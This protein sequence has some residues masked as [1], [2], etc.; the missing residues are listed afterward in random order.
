MQKKRRIY[1]QGLIVALLA[2]VPGAALPEEPL[3]PVPPPAYGN[4]AAQSPSHLRKLELDSLLA[5]LDRAQRQLDVARKA[6]RE[7]GQGTESDALLDSTQQVLD[8]ARARLLGEPTPQND[9]LSRENLLRTLRDSQD[10]LDRA[11]ERLAGRPGSE[12]GIAGLDEAQ[13]RLDA[14]KARLQGS[15][16]T[17]LFETPD[18]N[19]LQAM[20]DTARRR[21]G[22]ARAKIRSSG[23]ID[24]VALERQLDEAERNLEKAYRDAVAH[25]LLQ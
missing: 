5:N 22:L 8:Q 19:E 17:S 1:R 16:D 14:T 25:G 20:F 9:P 13:E 10:V 23:D 24:S 3:K 15:T 21:L 2:S 4:L 7:T 12:A 18:S 11:R 6:S